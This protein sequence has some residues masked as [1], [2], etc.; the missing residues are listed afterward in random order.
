MIGRLD[1]MKAVA[2][3]VGNEFPFLTP[4]FDVDKALAN[5]GLKQPPR[6]KG[7]RLKIISRRNP[8]RTCKLLGRIKTT[9]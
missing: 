2:G 3:M 1:T 9:C 8:N 6:G 4:E 5:L 7:K